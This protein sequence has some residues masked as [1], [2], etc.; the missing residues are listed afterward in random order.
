MAL[1][2]LKASYGF[3]T[4]VILVNK[5]EGLVNLLK[6]LQ[7]VIHRGL[8][9][10]KKSPKERL[11]VDY[12]QTRRELL[13][14]DWNLFVTNYTKLHEQ[15]E[16]QGIKMLSELYDNTED[17]YITYTCL[18]KSML[19]KYD[20]PKATIPEPG[21]SS[22]SNKS[23]TN[24]FVKLPKISIP[25]FSG[26]Y[27]EWTTFRDLFVSLV[28]NNSSL[29]NV[30][31][32]H[33]L[34][35]H[36]SGEAE[37][38]VRQTPVSEANYSQ[39]WA[40]LE[41]RYSNKKYL[42]NC[43]LK[44]L[45]GLKRMHVE[46]AISLKEL[47]DT[48]ND[49][50]RFEK[51]KKGMTTGKLD[52][53]TRKQWE[54][55]LSNHDSN[56]LPTYDE[57]AT[58]LENRFRALE[59]IEPKRTLQN[60]NNHSHVAK[61]MVVSS[62]NIRCEY[63]NESHKLC[64]CKRFAKEPL[65]E[66]RNFV[67]QHNICFNCL[68]GN[69]TVINCKKPTT[70]KLCHKRHHSLLHPNLDGTNKRDTASKPT[71]VEAS[72]STSSA[73]VVSCISTNTVPV[74][75]QVLLAT[76]LVKAESKTGNYQVVRALLDQG[77]QACFVTEDT[78][79]FLRLKKIPIHG[80]V[81]GLGQKSTIAKYMVNITIQSWVDSGFKLNFNAY[82]IS[83]L[84]NSSSYTQPC[85]SV[86]HAQ[87]NLDQILK[88]FWEIQ[89]Q[90]STKKVLSPEEQQCEDFYKATTK[91]RAD[92]RY[93]V[94]PKDLEINLEQSIKT[95]VGVIISD[96]FDL[97]ERFS[98]LSN[99]RTNVKKDIPPLNVLG[100]RILVFI[101]SYGLPSGFTGAPARK[102]GV[103]TGWFL[104]SK[105]DTP[106]RLAQEYASPFKSYVTSATAGQGVSGLF[107]GLSKVLLGFFR[108]F[109]IILS[110]STESGIVP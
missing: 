34:K 102:A 28:H 29:D 55:S 90:T 60:Q 31:K 78:V 18:I 2:Q 67:A 87:F 22:N 48:T 82:V 26:K 64:F 63:C 14:R 32:M 38:L 86:A 61:S 27:S 92:G 85:V 44:R 93:E 57:L 103:G 3:V 7:N 58:F 94:R 76:A 98:S 65:E 4:V 46:S 109:E 11:S 91:R 6:E 19:A 25:N 100:G 45:F 89:D 69:H 51:S 75:G 84:N 24:S 20:V 16:T 62:S 97:L 70:C 50:L 68:G 9:N 10:L 101:R 49:C 1:P 5:M 77:S 37:Q 17:T 30:Q 95:H 12:I 79:Q 35:S 108:L 59:F 110:S 80:M 104:V 107:P 15:Y 54:L 52:S 88:Q 66:R 81:S 99:L 39:C 73:P 13:E 74:P 72:P 53:E 105:S 41:K 42:V 83:Q 33:Y 96:D 8:T 23:S 40:Q 71:V 106:S 56:E 47:L 21:T 36:L 43:I